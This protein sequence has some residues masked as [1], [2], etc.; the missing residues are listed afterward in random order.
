MQP[1]RT[2]RVPQKKAKLD[3]NQ[4]PLKMSTPELKKACLL[5][6][7]LLKEAPSIFARAIARG[8]ISP[9]YKHKS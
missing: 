6:S 2:S 3:H 5:T 7:D 4:K 8:D 1:A 9:P